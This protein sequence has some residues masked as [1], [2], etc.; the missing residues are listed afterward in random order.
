MAFD[1]SM[2]LRG[3]VNTLRFKGL[4]G[5]AGIVSGCFKGGVH[6]VGPAG[7]ESADF[8]LAAFAIQFVRLLAK[9]ASKIT[10]RGKNKMRVWVVGMLAVYGACG[11]D[12]ISGAEQGGKVQGKSV[13]AG[14]IQFQRQGKGDRPGCPG[15]LALFRQ[16]CGA[17]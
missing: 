14:L 13:L 3:A 9:R 8:F 11:D 4:A 17:P 10:A 6:E 1:S 2:G 5:Y 16:L 15:V 7:A 12:A